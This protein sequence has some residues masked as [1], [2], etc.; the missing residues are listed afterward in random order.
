M[1]VRIRLGRGPKI[2]RNRSERRLALVFAALLTPLAAVAC[3]F[4]LWRIAADLRWTNSFAIPSGFF[5]HWQAWLGMA[6]LLELCSHL[7][8]RYGKGGNAALS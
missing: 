1:R 2:V 8:N 6:V 3:V 5:S 7:L 4:G